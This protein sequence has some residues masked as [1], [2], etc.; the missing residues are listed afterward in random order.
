MSLYISEYVRSGISLNGQNLAAG[1]EPAIATQKIAIGGSS[2][3]SAVFNADTK[4]I[5]VHAAAI[6]SIAFG[7]NPTATTNSMRL[8]A[9]Q[10][11]YFSVLP[12]MRLA[13]ITNT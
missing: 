5:R 3:Q 7:T 8:A 11:E 10:T 2:T 13:V 9:N 4:F 1:E 6:C 12:G